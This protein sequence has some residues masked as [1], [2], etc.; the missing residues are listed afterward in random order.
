[1]ESASKSH[2]YPGSSPSTTAEDQQV[3]SPVAADELFSGFMGN[4]FAASY[5][6]ASSP[7]FPPGPSHIPTFLGPG[8]SNQNDVYTSPLSSSFVSPGIPNALLD[9]LTLPINLEGP[10]STS[11]IDTLAMPALH[12]RQ[13]FS[14]I[15][16]QSPPVSTLPQLGFQVPYAPEE[17]VA[18]QAHYAGPMYEPPDFN[19]C[20]P[21]VEEDVDDMKGGRIF[22]AEKRIPSPAPS[23]SSSSSSDTSYGVLTRQIDFPA[24]SKEKLI[25]SFH[26]HTC[27]VLSIKKGRTKNPW[28]TL[29]WPLARDCPA[30][31][32][33]I[34]SLACFHQ[35]NELRMPRKHGI[36]HVQLSLQ[37]LLIG[38]EKSSISV[39]ALTATSLA[40]AFSESWD[41]HI[42][43]GIDHIKA[44]KT[45]IKQ[46][47]VE[48]QQR[49]RKGNELNRLRFLCNTW[50]YMDVIARLT[51]HLTSADDN[52]SDYFDSVFKTLYGNDKIDAHLDPLMGC[53]T[54]LF[55]IIGRVANLVRKV[56]R[57]NATPLHLISEASSLK[58]QLEQ[59]KPPS[60]IEDLEDDNTTTA[61]ICQTAI[62]YQ[63]ATL[64]Y[65]HQAV[66]E[67][68]SLPAAEL[69]RVALK[70]LATVKDFSQ[71]V[72]VSIYPLMATGCEATSQEDRRWVRDRWTM[73]SQRMKLGLT[74]KCLEV[75]KE[76]WRRRDAY[77]TAKKN[78]ETGGDEDANEDIITVSGN[79]ERKRGAEFLDDTTSEALTNTGHKRRTLSDP[80]ILHTNM[81]TLQ[82]DGTSLLPELYYGATSISTVSDL[83]EGRA[84]RDAKNTELD[85]EFTVRGRLHWLSV[86]K[87][88]EWEGKRHFTGANR[89]G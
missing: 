64:L 39:D 66:P 10:H 75:T 28:R 60:F 27:G 37:E 1:M 45:L 15:S 49:P 62:S 17:L 18:S 24:N 55:P 84:R 58:K 56:R 46:T 74:E 61:D 30:L 51:A 35:S 81:P 34:S 83:Y 31:E 72:I 73:L 71:S 6:T 50:V 67:I 63:Y 69:A 85:F 5:L 54:S 33:A 41:Q 13:S 44:A 82:F 53:A 89:L 77:A 9:P 29:V 14:A 19:I 16:V 65:L 22:S 78:I 23:N 36:E 20:T 32:H 42:R 48:H 4:P 7:T 52:D 40:L 38:V 86:M 43:T 8:Y 70:S 59:W 25:S 2:R 26:E 3:C 79:M 57:T 11:L 88:W 47:L 80:R 87:E 12:D 68:P 21:I 76:V